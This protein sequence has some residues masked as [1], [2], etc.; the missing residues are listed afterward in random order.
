[1]ELDKLGKVLYL[2]LKK[3]CYAPLF[4][5]YFPDFGAPVFSQIQYQTNKLKAFKTFLKII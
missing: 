5:R 1:M 2:S 4:I 3:H